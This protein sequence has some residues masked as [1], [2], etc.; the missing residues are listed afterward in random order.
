MYERV[1][2]YLGITRK[3]GRVIE[4]LKK[5]GRDKYPLCRIESIGFVFMSFIFES[6]TQLFFGVD[7]GVSLL[8]CSTRKKEREE[9]H[10]GLLSGKVNI[11]IGTHALIEDVVRFR[12]LGFVVIDEQHRFGVVQRARLWKKSSHPPHML[13]MTAPPIPRTLAM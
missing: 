6:F 1:L 8:T 5:V 7:V 11:L 9:I 12:N 13:V 4:A 2:Y 3:N 10:A